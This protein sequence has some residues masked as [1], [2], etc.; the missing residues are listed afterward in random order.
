MDRIVAVFRHFFGAVKQP[1]EIVGRFGERLPARRIGVDC[2]LEHLSLRPIT[3][4]RVPNR[5]RN[6]PLCVDDDSK[7]L[8]K[9]FVQVVP[10]VANRVDSASVGVESGLPLFCGWSRDDLRLGRCSP[11]LARLFVWHRSAPCSYL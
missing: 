5:K 7:K 9:L 4:G 1:F 8:A 2:C 11:T 3:F 10:F 6:H